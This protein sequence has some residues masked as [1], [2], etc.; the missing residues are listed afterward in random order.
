[1]DI[2]VWLAIKDKLLPKNFREC[3]IN[4]SWYF[5]MVLGMHVILTSSIQIFIADEPKNTR[6]RHSF[7]AKR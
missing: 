3:H 6:V 4:F 2:Y 5:N 7:L 1:M